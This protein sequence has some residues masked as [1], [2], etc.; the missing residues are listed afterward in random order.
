[1]VILATQTPQGLSI[2]IHNSDLD[3]AISVIDEMCGYLNLT[4]D[5]NS[6]AIFP[7]ESQKLSDLCTQIQEQT[8]LRTHFEANIAE[9]INNAKVFVVKGELSISIGDMESTK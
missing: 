8:K 7:E 3:I 9:A 4:N 1:M 5:M 2:S 6:Q